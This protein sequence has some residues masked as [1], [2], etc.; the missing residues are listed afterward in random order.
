MRTA[1]LFQTLRSNGGSATFDPSF[2]LP[3]CPRL[4][5]VFHPFDPHALRLEPLLDASFAS[6]GSSIAPVQIPHHLGRQ[7]LHLGRCTFRGCQGHDLAGAGAGG[8]VVVA[9]IALGCAGIDAAAMP[10]V[11][12]LR[13]QWWW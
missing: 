12:G 11:G 9:A 5:N 7:R 2:R 1:G 13:L 4:F 8:G 10:V 3:S 6:G